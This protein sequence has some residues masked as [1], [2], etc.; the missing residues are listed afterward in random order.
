VTPGGFEERPRLLLAG[1]LDAWTLDLRELDRVLVGG[2]VDPG[3]FVAVQGLELV[4][5]LLAC[6]A[7]DRLAPALPADKSQVNLCAAMCCWTA[8]PL[9]LDLSDAVQLNQSS[10]HL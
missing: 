5:D 7:V 2:N 4:G 8:K 3:G 10:S 9:L 1:R 6:L